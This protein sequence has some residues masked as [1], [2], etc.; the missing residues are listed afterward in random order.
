[1]NLLTFPGLRL[2]S[3][4]TSP[5]PPQLTHHLTRRRHETGDMTRDYPGLGPGLPALIRAREGAENISWEPCSCPAQTG[6]ALHHQPRLSRPGSSI[7][8]WGKFLQQ[9]VDC[10]KLT[11]EINLFMKTIETKPPDG[12]FRKLAEWPTQLRGTHTNRRT[13][14]HLGPETW[15][16]LALNVFKSKVWTHY[17]PRRLLETPSNCNKSLPEDSRVLNRLAE[18]NKLRQLHLNEYIS[19]NISIIGIST[20]LFC[21][22]ENLEYWIH[23][24]S[25]LGW[26]YCP[27]NN[28]LMNK[29]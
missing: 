11:F 5:R 28:D 8:I 16:L 23:L 24:F 17:F 19:I 25:H 13:T 26:K 2:Q 20:I 27:S 3:S 10:E 1:M 7:F 21:S 15:D 9:L 6:A 29:F 12:K 18:W 4:L 22:Q 14:Q